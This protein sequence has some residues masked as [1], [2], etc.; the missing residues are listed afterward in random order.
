M[1][2]IGWAWRA[3]VRS[4]VRKGVRDGVF[5]RDKS[6]LALGALVGGVKL[7]GVASKDKP[8][9]TR[10]IA[11]APGEVIELHHGPVPA[12]AAEMRRLRRRARRLLRKDPVAVSGRGR[13]GRRS[14]RRLY[15]ANVADWELAV[16][17]SRAQGT[18]GRKGRKAKRHVQQAEGLALVARTRVL[19]NGAD[20]PN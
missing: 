20:S 8:A 15:E 9:E 18:K 14:A 7:I 10:L 3:T 2:I 16:A 19:P 1:S 6:S 17:K 4:G 13:R 11:V 12:S 5:G